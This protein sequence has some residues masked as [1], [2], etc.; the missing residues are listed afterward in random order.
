M[1]DEIT[2]ANETFIGKADDA[3]LDELAQQVA[4]EKMRRTPI[5]RLTDQQLEA[6]KQDLYKTK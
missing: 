6:L 3:R 1:A 2:K 5:G 4:A